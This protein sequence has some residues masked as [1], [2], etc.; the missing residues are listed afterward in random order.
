[1]QGHGHAGAVAAS[2]AGHDLADKTGVAG[3]QIFGSDAEQ[4]VAGRRVGG[5]A[6][7]V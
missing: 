4:G 3:L 6:P 2:Q 7:V 1:M 5:R